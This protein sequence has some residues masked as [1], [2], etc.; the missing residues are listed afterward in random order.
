MNRRKLTHVMFHVKHWP[1]FP[2]SAASSERSSNLTIQQVRLTSAHAV[3]LV[4]AQP[5]GLLVNGAKVRITK[6]N[7]RDVSNSFEFP[8]MCT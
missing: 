3:V 4:L 5:R 7:H 2:Q 6:A 8:N 1:A